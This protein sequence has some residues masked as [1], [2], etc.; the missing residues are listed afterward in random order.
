MYRRLLF[1][2][3]CA[4]LLATAAADASPRKPAPLPRNPIADATA[5]F[6]AFSMGGS[7]QVA[8]LAVTVGGLCWYYDARGERLYRVQPVELPVG[9]E[10]DGWGTARVVALDQWG[11]DLY[12]P[13]KVLMQHHND[14][15]IGRLLGHAF[16]DPSL[17]RLG[18]RNK[19]IICLHARG[20]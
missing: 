20:L 2:L 11:Q 7:E 17:R 9:G 6:A 5:R 18:L 14:L 4:L 1:A 12:G 3:A 13:V 10:C 8:K 19:T 15:W 16:S